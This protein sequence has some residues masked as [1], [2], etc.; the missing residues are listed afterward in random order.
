MLNDREL[1]YLAEDLSK[2]RSNVTS[3]EAYDATCRDIADS[4]FLGGPQ[5]SRFLRKAKACS[6]DTNA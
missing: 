5:R 2:L 4:L 1:D 6:Y 3:P